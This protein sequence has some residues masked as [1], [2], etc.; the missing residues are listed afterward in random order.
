MA[1]KRVVEAVFDSP[2]ISTTLFFMLWSLLVTVIAA[3]HWDKKPF[4]QVDEWLGF[5]NF[6]DSSES[7]SESSVEQISNA[8]EYLTMSALVLAN[9][10]LGVGQ[11]GLKRL[12][13]KIFYMDESSSVLV[14]YEPRSGNHKLLRTHIAQGLKNG[15]TFTNLWAPTAISVQYLLRLTSDNP[16]EQQSL[17]SSL[18]LL[19]ISLPV[20]GGTLLGGGLFSLAAY[21]IYRNHRFIE[22]GLKAGVIAS[23]LT[24]AALIFQFKIDTQNMG[25]DVNTIPTAR[26][27][28]E[29]GSTALVL[30]MFVGVGVDKFLGK[31]L[32]IHSEHRGVQSTPLTTSGMANTRRLAKIWDRLKTTGQVAAGLSAPAILM[33]CAYVSGW[34]TGNVMAINDVNITTPEQYD[35]LVRDVMNTFITLAAYPAPMVSI[36][37]MSMQS[38]KR[39]ITTCSVNKVDVDAVLDESDELVNS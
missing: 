35:E 28:I 16:A 19:E 26:Q 31:R 8:A 38:F 39:L 21:A 13:K 27:L 9:T 3:V 15:M 32:G 18:G 17:L 30:G 23:S 20:L 11:H 2:L 7:T 6:D 29:W 24:I 22:T 14:Q 1:R 33:Y 12:Y 25:Y 5:G 4:A 10:A 37:F 36:P 34:I